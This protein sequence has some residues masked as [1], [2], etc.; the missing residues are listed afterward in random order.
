MPLLPTVNSGLKRL[1]KFVGYEL[2]WVV[3]SLVLALLTVALLNGQIVFAMVQQLGADLAEALHLIDDADEFLSGDDLVQLIA[4]IVFFA[5]FIRVIITLLPRLVIKAQGALRK[6]NLVAVDDLP[7]PADAPRSPQHLAVNL[8][9][10]SRQ[11]Q[12]TARLLIVSI[13][14]LLLLGF[15][16]FRGAEEGVLRLHQVFQVPLQVEAGNIRSEIDTLTMDA[17]RSAAKKDGSETAIQQRIAQR[18]EDLARVEARLN[19]LSPSRS[20]WVFLISSLGTKIAAVV[21]LIFLVQ[22][23]GNLY[24]YLT[25]LAFFDDSR[26][27]FLELLDSPQTI[28]AE[29]LAD[30]LGPEKMV[31]MDQMPAFPVLDQLR[32]ILKTLRH[33]G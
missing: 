25:R 24:R 33:R 16:M 29:K 26:A 3:V 31:E 1:G 28:G 8:R 22:I 4:L 10:R 6:M 18:R 7:K 17:E 9:A 11:L 21:F 2:F 30:I 20:L 23:L 32:D 15:L 13:V 12:R 14:F 5:I 27:D 19:E